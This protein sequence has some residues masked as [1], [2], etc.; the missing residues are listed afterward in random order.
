MANVLK[1][2]K[3]VAVL[4]ALVEGCSIRSS[5]RMFNVHRDTICRLLERMRDLPCERLE[6]DEMWSY[7]GKKERNM[8]RTDD[9]D[10][11]GDKWVYVAI[12]ATSKLIPS[13]SIGKRTQAT[14]DEFIADVASR[15]ANKVQVSTDGLRMYITAIENAFARTGVDYAQIVKRYEAEPLQSGGYSPPRVASTEKTAIFGAPVEELVSTSYVE[16]Q[17][18]TMRMGMRRFTRLTN[19]FSKKAENHAAAVALHVAHYNF[20]RI[21]KTL[22]VTPAMAI[23]IEQTV[24]SMDDLLAAAEE[25]AA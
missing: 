12:D 9:R 23:G 19:A 20:A 4:S 17:N 18:L 6:I 8:R 7:V 16:R 15:L 21:H 13:F 11:V 24:W 3:Q 5:E 10:R 22:R 14:T 25:R 1:R 2:E